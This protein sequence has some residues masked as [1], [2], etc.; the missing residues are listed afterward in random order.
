MSAQALYQR[1]IVDRTRMCTEIAAALQEGKPRPYQL[2]KLQVVDER[3]P[4]TTAQLDAALW[5]GASTSGMYQETV[6]KLFHLFYHAGVMYKGK[7]TQSWLD[8]ADDE[9]L[10]LASLLSHGDRVMVQIPSSDGRDPV[11][12]WLNGY[13]QEHN[14]Y[15]LAI[16]PRTRATHGIERLE[17]AKILGFAEHSCY[18]K[19]TKNYSGRPGTGGAHYGFNVALGGLGNRNPVSRTNQFD[20]V[21]HWDTGK[22]RP[23]AENGQDGHVFIN[24][25]PPTTNKPGAML[26]G[27]ENADVARSNPHTAVG[28]YSPFAADLS[29]CGGR[30]WG[31]R[32]AF[33]PKKGKG[34]IICDLT[35]TE[36]PID[37]L[38]ARPFHPDL[39]D[40]STQQVFAVFRF[41]EHD[42]LKA[43][44]K[45]AVDPKAKVVWH[46]GD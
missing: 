27:C 46:T 44:K 38:I 3:S 31:N 18:F 2:G 5:Y 9:H 26:V 42:P 25:L 37:R 28:H 7:S 29:A 20:D 22:F 24:Y 1:L 14:R 35:Y 34:L 11:W 33:G 36:W 45:A 19:E 40:A 41:D 13:D 6:K 4:M 16:P 10:K 12:D 30:K 32:L 15:T 43:A 17:P 21:L 23:I 39:L 8:W